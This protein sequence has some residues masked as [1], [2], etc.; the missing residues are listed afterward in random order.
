MESY[1]D[2]AN[3][4]NLNESSLIQ[5]NQNSSARIV[6]GST[7]DYN[8]SMNT[9]M[10]YDDLLYDLEIAKKVEQKR[11]DQ[12]YKASISLK[13]KLVKQEGRCHICTLMPPCRHFKK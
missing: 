3:F 13:S 8:P 11:L 12:I 6:N 7:L 1:Q 5:Q 4:L 10:D 9:S 2:K